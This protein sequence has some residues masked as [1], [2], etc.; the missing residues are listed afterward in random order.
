MK[1][2]FTI[3]AAWTAASSWLEQGASGAIFV[4]IARLV[5]AEAFG[6]ASMAF[7]FLFLGEFLVRDTITEAIVQRRS[8]EEGRLEA[9]FVTLIGFSLAIIIA[10]CIISQVAAIA[11]G[12][13]SVGP[14]LITA[15]PTV[16]MIGA[17]GVS[18]ALLRRKLA[19]RALAI[20]AVIAVIA[21]G[22]VGIVLAMNHFGAWALVGQRLT[23]IGINSVFAFTVAGWVPKRWPSRS[24]FALVR[25]LGPKVVLLRSMSLVII[26]T[27]TVALGLFADPRAVGLFAFAWRLVEIVRSLIISPIEGVAQSALAEVRRQ[28]GSTAQFYLDLTEL[29]ALGGF[30]AFAG[31]ALIAEPATTILAGRGWH[32]AGAILSVLCLVGATLA[33]TATQ[34][35]YLLA[36]D[37][38]HGFLRACLVEVVVGCFIIALASQFGPVAATW[39]AVLRTLVALPLRTRAALAPEAIAPGRFVQV[40]ASPILLAAG[41]SVFVGSWRVALLGRIPDV[42]FVASAIAI[43]VAACCILLFGLMPNAVAR[44]RT[45]IQA[46]Q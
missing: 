42:I 38:L 39:G 16:L 10:L 2:D 13:P 11:Y 22:I 36:L 28:H 20:R 34:E 23:Q 15:S 30:A 17:A 3:G 7:A 9:T 45:F 44:L 21:G 35:A 33:L 27:P 5:G 14:L 4:V 6:I 12:Q 24:D 41:M 25:G 26:Q 8:L 32:G 37:R 40:L 29:A 43:G 19:Y 46:E 18:T 1:R 31:L